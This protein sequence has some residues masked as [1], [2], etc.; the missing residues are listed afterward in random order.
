MPR[1]LDFSLLPSVGTRKRLIISQASQSFLV[2]TLAYYLA[3]CCDNRVLLVAKTVQTRQQKRKL[4][5]LAKMVSVVYT[6]E[7]QQQ[8]MEKEA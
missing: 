8:L 1:S 2:P 6:R 7:H 3:A 4:R 5:C